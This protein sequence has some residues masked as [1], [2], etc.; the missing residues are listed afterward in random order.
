MT[1]GKIIAVLL[2][3]F[4]VIYPSQVDGSGDCTHEQKE[5]IFRHCERYISEPKPGGAPSTVSICCVAVREVL[6]KSDMECIIRLLPGA[7]QK[8]QI[9][10]RIRNLGD[11]CAAHSPPN[12]PPPPHHHHPNH[13]QAPFGSSMLILTRRTRKKDKS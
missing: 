10:K 4:A 13:Q 9:V 8:Y 12:H 1:L 7:W 5:A 6:N 3:A 11:L 2:L